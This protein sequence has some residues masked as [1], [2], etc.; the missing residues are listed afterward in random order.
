MTRFTIGFLAGLATSIGSGLLLLLTLPLIFSAASNSSESWLGL[1]P[2]FVLIPA[3]LLGGYTAAR[4]VLFRRI[5]LGFVVG[6]VATLAVGFLSHGTGQALY[7]SIAV[8]LGGGLS[9]FGAHLAGKHAV[10]L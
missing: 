1:L 2:F 5:T 6:V 3:L 9:A 8:L 10:S 7:L 4:L